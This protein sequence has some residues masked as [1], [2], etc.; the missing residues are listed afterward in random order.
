MAAKGSFDSL[1]ATLGVVWNDGRLPP[2]VRSIE[3]FNEGDDAIVFATPSRYTGRWAYVR[4]PALI[5][6]MDIAAEQAT[7]MCWFESSYA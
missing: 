5:S 7:C 2:E 6:A 3:A 1:K 4:C